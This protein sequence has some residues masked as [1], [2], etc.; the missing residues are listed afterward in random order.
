MRQK[1]RDRA[2]ECACLRGGILILQKVDAD[3][4]KDNA[5]NIAIAVVMGVIAFAE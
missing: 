4:I 1:R 3:S 2:T 5:L